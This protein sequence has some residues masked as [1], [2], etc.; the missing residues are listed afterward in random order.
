MDN[1]EKLL[2]NIPQVEKLIQ[3]EEIG[4]FIPEIGHSVVA[5]VVKQ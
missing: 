3:H 4:K 1:K 2:R 5:S